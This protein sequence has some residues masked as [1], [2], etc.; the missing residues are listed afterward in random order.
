MSDLE[1][2]L[3]IQIEICL[4]LEWGDPNSKVEQTEENKATWERMERRT[5]IAEERGWIIEIPNELPDISDFSADDIFV[6]PEE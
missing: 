2:T 3:S 1:T 6:L 4:G 5:R